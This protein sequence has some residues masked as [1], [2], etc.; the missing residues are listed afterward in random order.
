MY[1]QHYFVHINVI[2][3]DLK[4]ILIFPYKWKGFKLQKPD[5]TYL[6]KSVQENPVIPNNIYTS[7][8]V[9]LNTQW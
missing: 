1:V 5:L 7:Y 6:E 9:T 8:I 4:L 3:P 2:F